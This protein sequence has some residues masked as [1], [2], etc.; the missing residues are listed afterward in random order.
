M[1]SRIITVNSDMRSFFS[2][3]ILQKVIAIPLGVDIDFYNP[4]Y[5]PSE[6]I[7]E[8]L[9]IDETDFVIVLSNND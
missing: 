6:S 8:E 7:S 3:K 9:F 2:G 1:S 4:Q 5:D